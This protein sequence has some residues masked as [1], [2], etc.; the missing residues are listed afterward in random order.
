[1]SDIY[2]IS[3]DIS[4]NKLRS[5]IEKTLKNYGFRIQYS[6]FQCIA[7]KEKI[8]QVLFSLEKVLKIYSRFI[9]DSDS[10]IIIGGIRNEKTN[11]ILGEEQNLAQ[12]LIY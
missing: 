11:Y 4:K 5:K 12:Y 3:Y 10:I 1:M 9:T 7:D 8:S 6:I 2:F